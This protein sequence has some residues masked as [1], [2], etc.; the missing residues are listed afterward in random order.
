MGKIDNHLYKTKHNKALTM[1]LSVPIHAIV[2]VNQHWS[3]NTGESLHPMRIYGVLVF[4]NALI[5]YKSIDTM[6]R[7]VGR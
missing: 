2:F 6:C 5:S 7:N 4:T 3:Q 1:V